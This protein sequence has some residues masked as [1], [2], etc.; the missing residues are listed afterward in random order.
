MKRDDLVEDPD[1]PESGP[2][3]IPRADG[4]PVLHAKR[5]H[6]PALAHLP[7]YAPGTVEHVNA[8]NRAA[9]YH[10]ITHH[11]ARKMKFNIQA[12]YGLGCKPGDSQYLKPCTVCMRTGLDR[13][14]MPSVTRDVSERHTYNPGE[15]WFIDGSD[16]T[17]YSMWGNKR[18]CINAVDAATCYRVCYYTT[19]NNAGEF[20]DFI[21]YL[22][23]LTRFRTG[24][25]V[26]KLY[27]DY[28][29]TYMDNRRVAQCRTQD[30][31]AIELVVTPPYLKA[32]N[33]YAEN[34]IYSNRKAARARLFN[35]LGKNLRGMPIKDTTKFWLMAWEHGVQTHNFSAYEPLT[36]LSDSITCLHAAVYGRISQGAPKRQADLSATEDA[37]PRAVQ[38]HRR[39]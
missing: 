35:L 24:N 7:Y 2:T 17:Q 25:D 14:Q 26:K 39:Y 18:Y 4:P 33:T 21:N 8:C 22:V 16:S 1:E 29:S 32:R 37:H 31:R 27:S 19:T 10:A 34:S 9:R 13:F 11:S 20:C 36:E 3:P 30:G 28:F 23:K 15:M 6:A 38:P 5:H 12:G